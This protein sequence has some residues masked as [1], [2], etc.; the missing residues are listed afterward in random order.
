MSI[1]QRLFRSAKIRSRPLQVEQLETRRLLAFNPTGAEQELLQ[2]TNRFRTDPGGEYSRLI[3]STSPIRSRDT[4]LQADLDGFGVNGSTLR[5]ELQALSP[6]A[7]VAW[8]E[9]IHGFSR[10][11]NAAMVARKTHFHSNSLQR[12][13]ALLDA[14]VN[15]RFRSGEKINSELVY[16][17]GKS[18]LH[19]YASYVI[20]W[21]S[22]PGG[23]QS[24]RPHRSALINSDFEQAGPAIANYSGSGFGP[25]VNTH[26]LANIEQPPAMV[27]GAIF[28]DRNDSTWYEASEGIGSVSIVFVGSAG[29]F[30]TNSWSAGGYQVELPPGSYTVTATGGGMRHAVTASVTIG[31]TN[32]WKNLIYDPD[33]IPPDSRETNNTRATATNLNGER[34]SFSRLSIHS[35]TDTDLF[36]LQSLGSGT[37]NVSLTFAHS[38][39]NLDLRLLSSSGSVIKNAASNS[40]NESLSHAVRRGETYYVQVLGRSGARNGPYSLTVAPPG[41]AAPVAVSDSADANNAS[42]STV[43]DVL[44]NDT[45][46]DGIGE[47]MTIELQGAHA[48]FQ[49]ESGK[50]RYTAPAGY[51]GVDRVSYVAKDDQGLRSA[52]A[53]IEVFVVDFD[54]D[55]PWQNGAALDVNDDGVISPIDALMAINEINGRGSRSLPVDHSTASGVIGFV[56]TNG[57]G[58][59]SPIDALL[60]INAINQA[61][62]AEGERAPLNAAERHQ[63][64][65]GPALDCIY[66]QWPV[67]PLGHFPPIRNALPW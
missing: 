29:T 3:A 63:V 11:H 14:G 48:A 37:L 59:L 23:M 50:V 60:V 30:R 39:G 15:L 40:N 13:Q 31:S 32:V 56:D 38:A 64:Q 35:A 44:A 5:A 42:R 26:V 52:P 43:I 20:N 36:Q 8:S 12:R 53:E 17:Y 4:L 7:P 54:S 67:A 22:G 16:G 10:S 9:G 45:D 34:Q 51:S 24:G 49:V 46:P 47:A 19:A 18:V 57:D 33:S 65:S 27:V 61:A 6:A 62:D 58:F 2:L 1:N 66:S 28:E 41:Q 55:T 25:F 21:G